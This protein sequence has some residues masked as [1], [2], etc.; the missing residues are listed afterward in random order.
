METIFADLHI[1]VGRDKH[2][3]PVKISA[4]KTLTLTNILKEA[5]RNK[6]LQM[7]GVIDCQSPAVQEELMDLINQGAANE[8]LGGGITFEELTLILGS[9]I[10]IY[11]DRCQGPIHVLC[12]LPTL[13]AMIQFTQWLRS[14]MK[15][16]F[17]SSQRYYGNA[18]ELQA[19]VKSLGGLFIPAHVFTPFKSLYGKGVKQSLTE[20]FDPNLIDAIELGLSADTTMADQINELHAYTYVSNS[21]AHSLSKIA[22]EYQQLQVA[23]P[24]F[25]E[26]ALALHNRY[27]R[28]IVANYGMNPKLGKYYHTVCKKCLYPIE[29]RSNCANCGADKIIKGVSERIK[30]LSD[31]PDDVVLRPQYIHQVPLSYIPGLGPKMYQRL[32]DAFQTEMNIIHF[33]T[34]SQL[35]AVVPER[36][37]HKIWQ[38]RTGMQEVSAGGGGKYGKIK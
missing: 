5:S 18:Q 23:D 8:R 19:F 25:N 36:I 14:R 35:Q 22:R 2:N 21:D 24:S 7:I 37:A 31:D 10:E 3:Y 6:G 32:L 13:E 9:E 34:K 15:N 26:L 30:E 27:E 28:T 33:A 16:I 38:L 20:V 4:G 17:L 1:H 29:G 12:Y 11:D